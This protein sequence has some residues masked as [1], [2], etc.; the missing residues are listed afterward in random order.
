VH[1]DASNASSH[2]ARRIYRTCATTCE[3]VQDRA[4]VAWGLGF[5]HNMESKWWVN[6]H[7]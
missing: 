1:A 5:I 7:L 6:G 3:Y 4:S 2:G